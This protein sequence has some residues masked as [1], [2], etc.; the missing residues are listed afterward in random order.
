MWGIGIDVGFGARATASVAVLGRNAFTRI[1]PSGFF[2]VPRLDPATGR[3]IVSPLFGFEGSRPDYYN[4]SVGGRVN[5][6]R[7]TL[8]GF[9]TAIVPLNDDGA[10]S[11]VIPLAGIEAAF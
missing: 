10:R 11:N 9:A 8:I 6:W 7:D 1:A 2:D 4:I 3:V 5:L